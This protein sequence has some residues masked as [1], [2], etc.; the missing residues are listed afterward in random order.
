MM[1]PV[2]KKP[3]ACSMSDPIV[4]VIGVSLFFFWEI[5]MGVCGCM[6]RKSGVSI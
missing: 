3:L 6:I 5:V 1:S 4:S 2:R